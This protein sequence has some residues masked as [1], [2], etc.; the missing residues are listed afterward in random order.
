MADYLRPLALDEALA[1]LAA[2]PWLV[3][4]GGTDIYPA[5]VEW[6]IERPALDLTAIAALKGIERRGAHWRIGATTTWSELIAAPLPPLFDGLRQAAREIGGVQIQNAGTIAGN[7]CNA[8]PAAD[9]V[10][11]LLALDAGIELS[12]RDGVRV[13]KLADFI[14]GA[15]ATALRESELV[16]AILVP[17]PSAERCV[18]LFSKLGAR[19]YLVISIVMVAFA[20]ELNA[21]GE[22]TRAGV[23]VG[24]CSAVAQ[25]LPALEAA[26]HGRRLDASLAE[27]V[28]EAHLAP[29]APIDDIR[30]SADYRRE[31]ALT[32]IRRGLVALG[33]SA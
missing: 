22:I 2:Q 8:A 31:A 13:V 23:A 10:P 33:A 17:A 25:R 11:C 3:L 14:T 32:L 7:L 15:R 27:I 28:T 21:R 1:A 16:T 29:L 4:A 26:L 19:R 18:S 20:L 9:G 24:A 6:P 30:A 12:A 5:H